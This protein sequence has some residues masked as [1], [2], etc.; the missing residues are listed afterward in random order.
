M[1]ET[2]PR[3]ENPPATEKP[4]PSTQD[5][6]GTGGSRPAQ[7]TGDVQQPVLPPPPPDEGAETRTGEAQ[8]AGSQRPQ[9]KTPEVPGGQI[10]PTPTQESLG[11]TPTRQPI[12]E[13]QDT[14]LLAGEDAQRF[15]SRWTRIQGQFVDDPQAA[16]AEAD[17]LVAEV[18]QTLA[19]T[20]ARNKGEL[21][22]QWRGEG[23]AVTEDL[24]TALRQYR[25]FFNRLLST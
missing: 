24:R 22:G 5:L 25:S 23:D 10:A 21:E 16:V 1:S 4:G 20:F 15:R 6:A 3:T 19:T 11:G 9:S 8:E 17:R 14:P 2:M 13:E 7:A 18:M 12:G